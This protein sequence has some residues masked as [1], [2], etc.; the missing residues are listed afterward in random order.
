MRVVF[1]LLARHGT[2]AGGIKG[3]RIGG[4]GGGVRGPLVVAT[5]AQYWRPCFVS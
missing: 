3:V 2:E 5:L 4:G 1:R